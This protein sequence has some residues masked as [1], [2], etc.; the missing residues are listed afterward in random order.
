M[1]HCA[2]A[3]GLMLAA[4]AAMGAGESGKDP[5][6]FYIAGEESKLYIGGFM[7]FR[8]LGNFRDSDTA[9]DQDD[10]TSGF[11]G[12]RTRLVFRGNLTD[13]LGF[14]LQGDGRSS[15]G[16]F[17]LLDAFGDWKVNDQTKVRW[18]QFEDLFLKEEVVSDTG[19]TAV[20]QST[21][22]SVF[23]AGRVQGVGVAWTGDRGRFFGSFN[24]GARTLNT[25][26]TS[27]AEADYG[28]TARGEFRWG[29]G[30]WKQFDRFA[31]WRGSEYAGMLGGAVRWQSGG[32]TGGTA[33]TDAL[34]FTIDAM[35]KGNGWHV[36]GAFGGR[37]SDVGG[38]ADRTDLGFMAHGGYFFTE[39]LEGFAR[40][41]HI[42]PDDDAGAASDEF[43]DVTVGAS[44]YVFPESNTLKLTGDVVYYLD[45]RAGS[46][47]VVPTATAAGFLGDSED[48][49]VAVRFQAQVVF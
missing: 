34:S 3:A 37:D 31:S 27:G 39:Q 14:Y 10:F 19:Q 46:A 12:A 2:I 20:E 44:Y 11:V 1:R 48:G 30:D 47:D 18:G 40:Y 49:E 23:T 43:K 13:E 38:G 41:S 36:F 42:I 7:Q 24:D 6:G 26:F 25:N 4:G 32:E 5:G 21:F 28:L 8:L 17:I 45:D 29:A 22:N 33:D 35:A 16:T 9:G 15:D